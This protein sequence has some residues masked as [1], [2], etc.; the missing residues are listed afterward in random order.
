MS[1]HDLMFRKLVFFMGFV[2]P[3]LICTGSADASPGEEDY[4]MGAE[5]Y[6]VGDFFEAM[7]PLRK[8]ADA[9]HPKAQV[10]YGLVLQ[11]FAQDVEA[12]SYFKKSADQGD[13][14]GQLHYGTAIL[15]GEGAKKDPLEGR[16]WIQ[17]AAQSGLD[18]AE[19]QMALIALIPAGHPLSDADAV[20]WLRKAVE[21]EFLPAVM[22]LSAAYRGGNFGLGVDVKMADELQALANKI[23][24]IEESRRKRRGARR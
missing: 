3:L 1:R 19:N 18:A 17:T 13:P 7:P 22:G 24:G 5:R 12:V 14:E 2:L 4:K 21:N 23:Q 15:T 9:G 20:H 10:L 16:K 8:A 6:S 11:G